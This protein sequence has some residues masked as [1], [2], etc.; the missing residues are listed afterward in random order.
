[1]KINHKNRH[2]LVPKIDKDKIDKKEKEIKTNKKDEIKHDKNKEKNKIIIIKEKNK[3][4]RKNK[5]NLVMKSE[6]KNGLMMKGFNYYK[7]IFLN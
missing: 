5:I 2:F 4:R 1:V 6:D 3:K 7:M